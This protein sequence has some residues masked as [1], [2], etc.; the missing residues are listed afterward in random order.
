MKNAK[1][2]MIYL[3][4]TIPTHLKLKFGTILA[5]TTILIIAT[6]LL[7]STSQVM[8]FSN[9]YSISERYDSGVRDGNRDCQNGSDTTAY[10]SSSAYLRHSKYYQKGYDN[11]VASCGSGGGGSDIQNAILNNHDNRDQNQGQSSTQ[12]P[13]C[14]TVFGNCTTLNGQTQGLT[15]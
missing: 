8:G 14:L 2:Q 3:K 11:T 4:P 15:N 13:F 5:L 1:Y 12:K 10:Q 6:A 9:K 7:S